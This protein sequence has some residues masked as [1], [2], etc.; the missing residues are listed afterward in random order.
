MSYYRLKIEQA[1]G[2]FEYSKTD[3]LINKCNE[4]EYM[5]V[6]PNPVVSDQNIN[7]RF[8]T[9]YTGIAQMMIFKMNG[10][11]ILSK[12]VQVKSGTNEISIEIKNLISGSYFINLLG[13]KGES[14]G[15]G[16]QFIK[17]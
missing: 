15:I 14:I 10:Q 8:T 1:S 3:S 4:I 5:R 12:S 16:A 13:S 7:L 11:K 6:F 2:L 9:S 17:Q